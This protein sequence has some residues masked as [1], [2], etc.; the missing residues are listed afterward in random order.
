MSDGQTPRMQGK[1]FL[2][3]IS[4]GGFNLGE[5]LDPNNNL[6]KIGN[7]IGS[8]DVGSVFDTLGDMLDEMEDRYDEASDLLEELIA[9]GKSKERRRCRI[10]P[11][12]ER[13]AV[14]CVWR[15]RRLGDARTRRTTAGRFRLTAIEI[16]L[17]AIEDEP[18]ICSPDGE[19]EVASPRLRLP[20]EPLAGSAQGCADHGRHGA[21][22]MASELGDTR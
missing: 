7:A 22:M 18:R 16:R 14:G 10:S 13:S 4:I 8:G 20:T 11:T 15:G 2:N 19:E 21:L 9:A 1:S 6:D 3:H 5:A 12:S 17:E